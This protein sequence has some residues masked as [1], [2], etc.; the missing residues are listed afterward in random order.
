VPAASQHDFRVHEK[1]DMQYRV[2]Y[3]SRHLRE[4]LC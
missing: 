4:L 1:T 2:L 3:N